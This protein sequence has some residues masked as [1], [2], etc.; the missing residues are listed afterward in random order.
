MSV[1]IGDIVNVDSKN[2]KNLYP[3]NIFS[4]SKALLK[5]IVSI[6]AI[7]KVA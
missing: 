3:V 7:S 4:Y 1:N 5:T 2:A 6:D